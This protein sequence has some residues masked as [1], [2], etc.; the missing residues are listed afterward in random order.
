MP[1]SDGGYEI[2][3]VDPDRQERRCKLMEAAGLPFHEYLPVRRP[4]AYRKQ[5][6]LPGYYYFS[7]TQRHL[8]YESR[9]EMSVLMKMDFDRKI[10][11][12]AAQP[13]KLLYR[14]DRKD[15]SHVPDFFAKL[16]DGRELVVDVKTK[17]AAARP[18]NK[19]VFEITADA[20]SKA[21]WTHKVDTGP[22]E[23]LL[24]NIRWL[25]GFRRELATS[26]FERYARD[27]VDLCS[28]NPR[29]ISYLVRHV[30]RAASVRP[31]LFHLLWKG[32]VETPLA[33][34]LSDRSVVSLPDEERLGN[35][36]I[37]T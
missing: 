9:L 24:S 30:G 19:R 34:P 36:V 16:S 23:P 22:E 7:T 18:K 29:T 33:S 32:I 17:S 14:R 20:C 1:D 4:A 2:I 12:V 8:L 26:D 13:F 5:R 6:H 11:G 21:G 31:I 35:D 3:F 28:E 27:I 25:A 15:R 10:V 37:R